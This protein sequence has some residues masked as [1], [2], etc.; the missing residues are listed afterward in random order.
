V[1]SEHVVPVIGGVLSDREAYRYL[2]RSTAYLPPDYE[3]RSLLAGAGFGTVGRRL[4]HGGLS[5]LLTAT[6][7]GLPRG[8]SDA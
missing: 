8:T 4:L 1:W 3:L 5:Q 6:R 2:P 7:T